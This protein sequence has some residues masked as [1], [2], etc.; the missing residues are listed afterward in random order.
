VETHL[1]HIYQKR[2]IT[3]RNEL[4]QALTAR[5]TQTTSNRGRR[6]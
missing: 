4:D 3:S 2:G 5:A 6:D 1:R